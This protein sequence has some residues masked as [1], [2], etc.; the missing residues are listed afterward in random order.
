MLSFFC[1]FMNLVKIMIDLTEKNSL[2]LISNNNHSC[3]VFCH[4]LRHQFTF[5]AYVNAK[6]GVKFIRAFLLNNITEIS[7]CFFF[8]LVQLYF[9]TLTVCLS[10]W[11]EGLKL[12]NSLL[13]NKNLSED[14]LLEGQK[15]A[16]HLGF[17]SLQKSIFRT[18]LKKCTSPLLPQF[19]L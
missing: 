4:N 18:F 10:T 6:L 16:T 8:K 5:T 14:L 13:Q 2:L 9:S 3:L 11:E 19:C 7:K 12:Q 17:S 15:E 1:H